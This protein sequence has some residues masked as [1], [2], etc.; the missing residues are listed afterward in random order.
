MLQLKSLL[1]CLLCQCVVALGAMRSRATFFFTMRWWVQYAFFICK[2]SMG[3]GTLFLQ[4][5]RLAT[6]K[7]CQS[8]FLYCEYSYVDSEG[9][10][11]LGWISASIVD[12][13]PLFLYFVSRLSR[14]LHL[15]SS[16]LLY[17][18]LSCVPTDT[19]STQ[20]SSV[21]RSLHCASYTLTPSTQAQGL[22][23]VFFIPYFCMFYL[24]ESHGGVRVMISRRGLEDWGDGCP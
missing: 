22:H 4:R 9:R 18:Y 14:P 24:F 20:R 13:Y 5:A 15:H 1:S 12:H 19:L 7:C 21:P 17:T 11:K 16:T 23:Y 3:P 10:L 2:N 8:I 6:Y